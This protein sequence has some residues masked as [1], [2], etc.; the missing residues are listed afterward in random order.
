[1]GSVQ[2][3]LP[4]T[5]GKTILHIQD[6][7]CNYFAQ[8]S[9]SNII[10]YL[11]A[12]HGVDLVF[13]E[14]GSGQYDLSVFTDIQDT[15]IREEIADYFVREGRLSGPEYFKLLNPE[16]VELFGV[17]MPE[18]YFKNLNAFRDSMSFKDEA[19]KDIN[20]LTSMVL[21]YRSKI[22]SKEMIQVSGSL[23]DQRGKKDGFKELVLL[24]NKNCGTYGVSMDGYGHFNDLVKVIEQEQYID[25]RKARQERNLLTEKLSKKLSR[26]DEQELA[27]M[28]LKAGT[29]DI[30][31]DDLYKYLFRKAR[32][33]LIDFDELPNLVKY[34]AYLEQFEKID[35]AMLH[36]ELAAIEEKLMLSLMS[37]DDQK[38]LY[39]IEKHLEIIGDLLRAGLVKDTYLYYKSHKSEFSVSNIKR[40][41]NGFNRKHGFASELP[42]SID[43]LDGFMQQMEK[44]YDCSFERDEAFMSKINDKLIADGTNIAVLVTGGFHKSNL[45]EL[46]A[47]E[48]YS[49]ISVMPKFKVYEGC[50]YFRLLSGDIS[51][52]DK[53]LDMVM[54]LNPANANIAILSAFSDVESPDRARIERQVAVLAKIGRGENFIVQQEWNESA[55][56]GKTESSYVVISGSEIDKADNL[57]VS[58]KMDMKGDGETARTVSVGIYKGSKPENEQDAMIVNGDLKNIILNI[59]EITSAHITGSEN[60]AAVKIGDQVRDTA[61]D[62]RQ[63]A[64]DVFN[65][66][67]PEEGYQDLVYSEKGSP[68]D[69]YKVHFRVLQPNMHT[70]P[71]FF[72]ADRKINF[73]IRKKRRNVDEIDICVTRETMEMLKSDPAM[74]EALKEHEVKDRRNRGSVEVAGSHRWAWAQ[75]KFGKNRDGMMNLMKFMIDNM[76]PADVLNLIEEYHKEEK[77]R[78]ATKIEWI[79]DTEEKEWGDF[80]KEVYDYCKKRIE[81]AKFVTLED[82]VNVLGNGRSL[83]GV[84]GSAQQVKDKV[85]SDIILALS[86]A[87]DTDVIEVEARLAGA[88]PVYEGLMKVKAENDRLR[89]AFE[90]GTLELNDSDNQALLLLAK[91]THEAWLVSE[92]ARGDKYVGYNIAIHRGIVKMMAAGDL[93]IEGI[94]DVNAFNGAKTKFKIKKNDLK[95]RPGNS[96]AD[97]W[98]LIGKKADTFDDGDIVI[99]NIAGS[100]DDLV[101]IA[102]NVEG[103]DPAGRKAYLYQLQADSVGAIIN[104]MQDAELMSRMVSDNV[105]EAKQAVIEM[106]R[107]INA[108]WRLK[109]PWGG[110]NDKLLNRPFDVSENGIGVKEIKKDFDVMKAIFAVLGKDIGKY[111]L[112][113]GVVGILQKDAEKI[114]DILLELDS[115]A[116][117]EAEI[118]KNT[119]ERPEV[120]SLSGIGEDIS[121]ALAAESFLTE[122]AAKR[123]VAQAITERLQALG[124]EDEVISLYSGSI[125]NLTEVYQKGDNDFRVRAGKN[126]NSLK[127][128]KLNLVPKTV[129]DLTDMFADKAV[130]Q[131]SFSYDVFYA[132]AEEWNVRQWEIIA[133][134]KN[135]LTN[136]DALKSLQKI[137]GDMRD[138]F[139]NETRSIYDSAGNDALA[140][141]A[142]Q[143]HQAWLEGEKARGYQYVGYNKQIH[144]FLLGLLKNG[145]LEIIGVKDAET[146]NGTK[147]KFKIKKSDLRFKGDTAVS[148]EDIFWRDVVG[149]DRSRFGDDDLVIKMVSGEWDDLAEIADEARRKFLFNLQADSVGTIINTF[150]TK[151]D[152]VKILG[153]KPSGDGRGLSAN[154]IHA[155][156]RNAIIDMLRNI[157]AEWRLK[158]PWGGFT[159][160]LL[161]KAFDTKERGGIGT[162]EI[163]KDF[164][165]FKAIL[166]V[167]HD[168]INSLALESDVKD[169]IIK[170]YE[171]SQYELDRMSN[172]D[173][174]EKSIVINAM[175]KPGNRQVPT[176]AGVPAGDVPDEEVTSAKMPGKNG[177]VSAHEINSQKP[178]VERETSALKN[179]EKPS[180]VIK[181]N[182]LE[183]ISVDS[184]IFMDLM[185]KAKDLDM[186]IFAKCS[187]NIFEGEETF[188]GI[189]RNAEAAGEID[190]VL[191]GYIQEVRGAASD[192]IKELKLGNITIR[193]FDETNPDEVHDIAAMTEQYGVNKAIVFTSRNEGDMRNEE[194]EKNAYM[195]YLG[196]ENPE[197]KKTQ[198]VEGSILAGIAYLDSAHWASRLER[199]PTDVSLYL[200]DINEATELFA[201]RLALMSGT[202]NYMDFLDMIAPKDSEQVR[203]LVA[204]GEILVV[205]RP[206]NVNEIREFYKAETEVLRSL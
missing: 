53:F 66:S 138:K 126:I 156:Q 97:F 16:A 179:I 124:V 190:S 99:K 167:L 150:Q 188:I 187:K 107:N 72:N 20:T 58:F 10:G 84:F 4:G 24:L 55:L 103:I 119:R 110:Y 168:N 6:A 198:P 75:V 115:E 182:G 161:N 60:S 134:M 33:E 82:L 39:L 61:G 48:G 13:L 106:L 86:K 169:D 49:Y 90:S 68:Y 36:K 202:V 76:M 27:M 180:I 7:H 121:G 11:S 111:A 45:R 81:E 65:N 109:N 8:K 170:A 196:T 158:N 15:A 162:D 54:A 135:G 172:R 120:E 166:K 205:I 140:L 201:K 131:G 98:K 28:S 44:F 26:N 85:N 197:G 50:P 31:E 74:L 133:R 203:R 155:L 102:D 123:K 43:R 164:A 56:G 108:V 35:K 148:N 101:E 17:E 46:C 51:E 80:E 200:E 77:G 18:L 63:T 129:K 113:P 147:A 64:Q 30:N 73:A 47:A 104:A 22:Y 67:L 117:L 145:E 160:I 42:E 2:D 189:G 152:L 21:N 116:A 105:D 59:S 88:L 177:G 181:V 95:F 32:K 79:S 146:F 94:A 69:G 141:L 125:R 34:S 199:A 185:A 92:K 70:E 12:N 1:M 38:D 41:F 204:S 139:V 173:E 19:E 87:W 127:H 149:K 154:K 153:M 23:K 151:R 3:V 5:N 9:I 112:N 178:S 206:I 83:E 114:N 175:S 78:R 52:F 144:D 89:K 191:Q 14:G 96:A 174:M 128:V 195:V 159:D 165:V 29:K 184:D 137:S 193:F 71:V 163:M 40:L 62:P 37:E 143:T 157:N 142:K 25:F 130:I 118:L 194:V 91:E 57:L 186:G 183:P 100:W 171:A 192:K 93:T 176:F 132:M 122:N 136:Y